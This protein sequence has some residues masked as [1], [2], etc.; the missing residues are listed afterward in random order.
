MNMV[1]EF[2]LCTLLLVSQFGYAQTTTVSGM[3]VD[4]YSLETIDGV[5]V[6]FVNESNQSV[7]VEPTNLSGE[8]EI[9]TRLQPGDKIQI[10]FSKEG[11][12]RG[13][14]EKV[15]E[16]S[17]LNLKINL[18]PKTPGEVDGDIRIAGHVKDL[19]GD[20]AAIEG[21][22][23]WFINEYNRKI[24]VRASDKSG[25]FE[26]NTNLKPGDDVE[27]FVEN[28][29][30][31]KTTKAKFS[32]KNETANNRIDIFLRPKGF[33]PNSTYFLG[34]GGVLLTT[35]LLTKLGS[36]SAYDK[37]KDFDNE[38]RQADFDKA[39][40]LNKVSILTATPGLILA[41]IGAYTALTGNKK[42]YTI[43]ENSRVLPQ[44]NYRLTDF[45]EEIITVGLTLKF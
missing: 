36:N 13:F 4:A 25:Y 12:R 29:N 32:I 20:N 42:L 14:I 3:V 7:F 16:R 23:V 45:G 33:I 37:H 5:E 39:N 8:F 34:G 21:A 15:I 31:H 26:I 1:K 2:I 10:H 41:G 30:G 35:G 24:P 44:L 22:Q 43:A 11:Y 18:E 28:P 6:A 38:N 19:K 9:K 17:G 40:K 27:I